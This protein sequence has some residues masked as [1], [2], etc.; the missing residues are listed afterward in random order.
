MTQGFMRIA[1]VVGRLSGSAVSMLLM[2]STT[3]GD[4]CWN[5]GRL[6]SIPAFTC[7]YVQFGNI[8]VM[9]DAMW[10]CS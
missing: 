1:A 10:A 6:Y 7:V 2:R 8:N 5:S 9:M 3:T 4:T